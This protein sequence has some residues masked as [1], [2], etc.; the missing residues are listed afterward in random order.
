MPTTTGTSPITTPRRTH[1]RGVPVSD[2]RHP[3]RLN[4]RHLQRRATA[5]ADRI[6]LGAQR[7]HPGVGGKVN[8]IGIK[9]CGRIPASVVEAYEAATREA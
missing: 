1:R 4:R 7:P 3:Q 6:Q 5:G 8:R 9:R 2:H